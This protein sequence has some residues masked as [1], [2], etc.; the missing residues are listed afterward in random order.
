LFD[1]REGWINLARVKKAAGV[2]AYDVQYPYRSHEATADVARWAFT[3]PGFYHPD[4]AGTYVL[5]YHHGLSEDVFP[6]PFD[7]RFHRI[8]VA[9]ELPG[10]GDVD[11]TLTVNGAATELK[12]TLPA[13]DIGPV[14]VFVREGVEAGPDDLIQVNPYSDV[15]GQENLSVVVAGYRTAELGP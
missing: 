11:V 4:M 15:G 8:T 9:A 12:A 14:T 5:L 13:G 6:T 2:W 10:A 3:L 1:E 7:V